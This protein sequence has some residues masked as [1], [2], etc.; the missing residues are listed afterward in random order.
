MTD[1][2]TNNKYHFEVD[3]GA[4]KFQI[5]NAVHELFPGVTVTSVNTIWVREKE[6]RFRFIL[7]S[8]KRWKK[9]IVTLKDG[10]SIEFFENR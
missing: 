5:R 8:P 10:D 2:Q 4:R 6:R 9:A 7:S 1:S 3:G